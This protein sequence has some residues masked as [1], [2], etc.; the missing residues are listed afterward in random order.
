MADALIKLITGEG[1][2]KRDQLPAVLRRTVPLP[3]VTPVVV[4]PPGGPIE[5]HVTVPIIEIPV[6]P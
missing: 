5:A 1:S 3:P 6:V 2:D 4:G